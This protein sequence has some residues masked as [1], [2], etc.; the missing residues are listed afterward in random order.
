MHASDGLAHYEVLGVDK[1]AT[2]AEIRK[3]FR[4]KALKHHPDK[5]STANATAYFQQI[6]QA[7]EVLNSAQSRFL[8]DR[9]LCNAEMRERNEAARQKAAEDRDLRES[10]RKNSL[11]EAS[12]AGATWEAMKL[13]R[14]GYSPT[15]LNEVDMMG[16]TP[17]MYAAEGRHTQ[18]VT[19]L[20]LYKADVGTANSYGWTSIMCAVSPARE[21]P[22]DQNECSS[23]CLVSLLQAKGNPNAMTQ[24]GETPLLLACVSGSLPCIQSLLDYAADVNLAGVSGMTPLALAADSGHI[25]VVS[26]LLNA[27]AAVDAPDCA[28][29]TALMSASALA[30]EDVVAALLEAGAD[31]LAKSTDGCTALSYAVEYLGNL[32]LARGAMPRE[33]SPGKNVVALLLAAQADIATAADDGKTP[34][35]LAQATGDSSLIAMFSGKHTDW[36]HGDPDGSCIAAGA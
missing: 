33:K 5:D 26:C 14:G 27:A 11:V 15:D 31:P 32:H 25:A 28:G 7:Y 6:L 18:I 8:Y 1:L 2:S 16:R 34:L 24:A 13:L 17:L 29:R 10:M 36:C 23:S 22:M 4:Q 9:G 12:K 3:A 19:L 35:Q 20:I 21:L 30:H